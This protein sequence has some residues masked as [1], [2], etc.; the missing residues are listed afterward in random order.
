MANGQLAR[1]APDSTTLAAY[2]GLLLGI[3][4]GAGFAVAAMLQFAPP[5]AGTCELT[6]LDSEGVRALILQDAAERA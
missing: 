2:G 3:V 4:A 1:R 5:G 6:R